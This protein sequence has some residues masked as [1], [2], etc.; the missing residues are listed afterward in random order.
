MKNGTDRTSII[1]A[2][3]EE[4]SAIVSACLGC[5]VMF[6]CSTALAVVMLGAARTKGK[7]ER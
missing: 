1:L 4:T 3:L 5:W 6:C 2:A 7:T